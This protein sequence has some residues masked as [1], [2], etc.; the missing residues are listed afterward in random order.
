MCPSAG[1]RHSRH[2][3]STTRVGAAVRCTVVG[4][5]NAS[6]MELHGLRRSVTVHDDQILVRQ[7]IPHARPV[8]R[9]SRF[10]DARNRSGVT[11]GDSSSP[12]NRRPLVASASRLFKTSR[13]AVKSATTATDVESLARAFA[14]ASRS[15]GSCTSIRA[16]RP[17]SP[18]EYFRPNSSNVLSANSGVTMLPSG[19]I[20]R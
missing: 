18:F 4:H 16:G 12:G 11:P 3:S 14:R 15:A 5:P 7:V 6:P 2:F 19:G 13:T 20:A 9:G 10:R 17:S 8:E 1:A